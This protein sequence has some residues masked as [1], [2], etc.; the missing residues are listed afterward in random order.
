MFVSFSL[1]ASHTDAYL[2]Y[3]HRILLWFS[4][5]LTQE[6][7]LED[8]LVFFVLFYKS[9]APQ[10]PYHAKTFLYLIPVIC[11]FFKAFGVFPLDFGAVN[12]RMLPDHRSL[13]FWTQTLCDFAYY[14]LY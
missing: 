8:F 3:A 10:A 7:V 11:S 9:L 2:T 5:S 13:V 14:I 4:L 1:L 12:L 6:P